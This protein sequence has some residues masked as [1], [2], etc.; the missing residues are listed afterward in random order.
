MEHGGHQELYIEVSPT[1]YDNLLTT[2]HIDTRGGQLCRKVGVTLAQLIREL[3]EKYR[4]VRVFYRTGR[5]AFEAQRVWDS[6]DKVY[7]A[8]Q[9]NGKYRLLCME[10]I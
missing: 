3:Q 7:K 10:T 2:I 4:Q 5:L 9:Y 1:Y 6:Y 8:Y